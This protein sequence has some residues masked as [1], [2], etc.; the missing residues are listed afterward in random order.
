MESANTSYLQES[1]ARSE[2][3]LELAEKQLAAATEARKRAN[4]VENQLQDEV[5]SL[6]KLIQV[7]RGRLNPEYAT[8]SSQSQSANRA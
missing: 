8:A 3:E 7:R 4:I 1:I 5:N 2:K 6:R